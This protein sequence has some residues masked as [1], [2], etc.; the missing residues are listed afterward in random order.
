MNND[1]AF[2][3]ILDAKYQRIIQAIC[4]LHQVSLENAADIF[5]N[6]ETMQ[7][8]EDGISDLHCRSDKYLAELIWDEFNEK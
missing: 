5:Y 4:E 3:A 6:S 7:L 1:E 8:I 2:H